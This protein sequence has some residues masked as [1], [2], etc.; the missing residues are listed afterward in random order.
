MKQMILATFVTLALTGAFLTASAE[1]TATETVKEAGR[2][3]VKHT[4]KLGREV[5][6][7]TCEMINGKMECTMKKLKHKAQ[8]AIDEVKDKSDDKK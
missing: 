7:K 1:Q 5:Q 6:D 3:T 8:N 2:D 4:K